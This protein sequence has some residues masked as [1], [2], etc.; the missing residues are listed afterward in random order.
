MPAPKVRLP[1]IVRPVTAVASA[2]PPKVK[3]PDIVVVPACNVFVPLP[4]NPR[5]TKLLLLTV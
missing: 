1:P 5:F 3:L 2:V 4:D